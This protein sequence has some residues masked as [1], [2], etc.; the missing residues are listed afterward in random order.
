MIDGSDVPLPDESGQPNARM[1][2]AKTSVAQA[3]FLEAYAMTGNITAASRRSD[4]HR[5][6]HYEWLQSD[7]D[8]PALFLDAENQAVDAL[9]TEARRRALDGTEKPVY[10]GGKLVG[11]VV[12]YSD[13]LIQFLLKGAR[14]QKYRDNAKPD[15]N[16]NGNR[17]A[18]GLTERQRQILMD[19]LDELEKAD[20]V[21]TG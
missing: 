1:R 3:M 9:E 8:Y 10:Q 18:V 17:D 19:E 14:P 2:D 6:R 11:S 16:D 21:A 20:S 13:N 12:E 7:P 15:A 4:V 5:Q